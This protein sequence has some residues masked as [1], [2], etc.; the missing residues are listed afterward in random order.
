MELFKKTT[1][2]DFLSRRRIAY[3][4]SLL[5]ILASFASLALRGLNFGIDFTGGTLV[6]LGYA[7][8]VDLGGVRQT[9]AANGYD[10]A[11][12]QHFGTARDVLIR[13]APRA[14]VSSA[15]LST[16]VVR[17][18]Q[19]A[20]DGTVELRRVEFVGPQVGDEL[21]EAGGLAMLYALAGILIYVGFR[22]RFT[23]ALGAIVA[24][25][26]D[27]LLTVVFL[28]WAGY[29]LTLNVIA[30]L[31]AI[32]GYSVNDTIVV[33]DRVRE[34]QRQM[35]REPLDEIVNKSVNQ[36]ISRTIITAGTTLLAVLALLIFGGE[37]LRGFALTMVIGVIVGTYSTVFIAAAIAIILSRR[38]ASA[39]V[40]G[41]A[42]GSAKA[43]RA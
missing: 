26:H 27:I 12:V 29:D 8:D 17:T 5:L 34:N 15:D 25:L 6:E 31:L 35:R 39:Q 11:I 2:I 38:P 19:Q 23:F 32:S 40:Q 3:A 24:S 20:A 14:D 9:L 42:Q 13:L 43:K 1:H 16:E 33:F 21:T 41:R 22:F 10:G 30:A 37:V 28:T 36:T 7:S 4:L 18:L